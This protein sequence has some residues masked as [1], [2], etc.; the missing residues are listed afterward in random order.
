MWYNSTNKIIKGKIMLFKSTLKLL[1]VET[2]SK[3]LLVPI[4]TNSYKKT[5]WLLKHREP[6]AHA[7]GIIEG[8]RDDLSFLQV[9]EVNIPTIHNNLIRAT[10]AIYTAIGRQPELPDTFNLDYTLA[11]EPFIKKYTKQFTPDELLILLGIGHN[12]LFK[13]IGS[14]V[15]AGD[16]SYTPENGPGKWSFYDYYWLNEKYKLTDVKSLDIR[17]YINRPA[18]QIKFRAHAVGFSQ[19]NNKASKALN[20]TS[21]TLTDVDNIGSSD[22]EL[23]TVERDYMISQITDIVNNIINLRSN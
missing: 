20:R 7:V 17:P 13:T 10:N 6:E 11:L 19:R 3:E 16:I 2:P 5:L 9:G 18:L 15:V 8:P 14:L 12:L 4:V 22:I 1:L 23:S 21:I